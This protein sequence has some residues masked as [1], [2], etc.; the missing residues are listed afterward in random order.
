MSSRIFAA[1]L[2][3]LLAGPASA[4][5]AQPAQPAAP[6]SQGAPPAPVFLSDQNAQQTREELRLLL[7]Q[8]PP[9]VAR[10]L[11]LD[12]ALLTN[13]S[14]LASYPQLAAF[15]A[16]QPEVVHNPAYFFGPAPGSDFDGV[17]PRIEA[18]RMWRNMGEGVMIFAVF[19]LVAGFLAWVVKTFIEYR[20]WLQ[21]SRVQ[22]DAH[23]KLLDRLT[24]H[25]EL[26]AYIQTPAGRRFL[27]SAPII[28]AG[29]RAVSAPIGRVIWSAQIGMVLAFAGLGLN[30]VS[31][32]VVEEVQPPLFVLG[33]LAI[34]LGIGF[35][36]SAALAYALSR[37][38]GL[39][40][41]RTNA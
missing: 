30:F 15:V 36:V 32:R 27:E 18:I 10:V 11:A 16:K 23:N 17:D 14:Y 38:F 12:P 41:P 4:Q 9:S 24:G 5:P 21:V 39:L 13:Q 25:E 29:P 28:D 1:L 6:Q 40:E 3:C 31:G 37:R 19:S 35:V 8:Y 26:L 7:R 2:A 22:T 33:V 34:A 20:R